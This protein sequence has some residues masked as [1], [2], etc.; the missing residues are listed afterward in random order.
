M[1]T[2]TEV[3]A[4]IMDRLSEWIQNIME[5]GISGATNWLAVHAIER[6][7]ALLSLPY[8]CC[9]ASP[10]RVSV[11]SQKR[12]LMFVFQ[13]ALFPYPSSSSCKVLLLLANPTFIICLVSVQG[14]LSVCTWKQWHCRS[15][16]RYHSGFSVA[17]I[18]P[19]AW[20]VPASSKRL[21]GGE[22]DTRWDFIC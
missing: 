16:K 6:T 12:N 5:G 14:I 9:L 20:I 2:W 18:P 17:I 7:H 4:A 15:T 8:M 3:R 13:L 22:W 11:C 21:P 1:R 10:L 19:S